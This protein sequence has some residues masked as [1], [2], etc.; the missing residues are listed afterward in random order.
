MGLKGFK[1]VVTG[2]GGFV[3]YHLTQWLKYI[4]EVDVCELDRQSFQNKDIRDK[5]VR[6]ADVVFHLAGVNRDESM[7][8][9][10][11]KNLSLTKNIIESLE[12]TDSSAH[13]VFSSSTQ[14]NLDNLYGKAKKDSRLLFESWAKRSTNGCFT[15]VVIPNVFGPFGRPFYNSVVATF[16]HLFATGGSPEID[17][18]TKLGL[19]YVTDLVK[20]LVAIAQ[21]ERNSI[22]QRFIEPKF[23]TSVKQ[24][25]DKLEE[26]SRNYLMN[27]ELP[28]LVDDFDKALFNTFRSYIPSNF[29]PKKFS[30]HKD[31]R[32]QFVELARTKTPG[33]TSYSTTVPGITRGNHFHT[34]K[35]ER[36][37]VIKGKATVELRKIGTEEVK[38]Y[39][40]DG[41]IPS[42]VDMPV[43]VTHN[44]TNTGNEE[45][46]TVF[47]INEPFDPNDPDTYFEPV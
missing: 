38:T 9:L 37:A 21:S 40:L 32:G 47:W 8:L 11:E 43:W 17:A 34:R 26:I 5:A 46:L 30:T 44:I 31:K 36:F 2:S 14:E 4:E 23:K 27:N 28:S 35:A 20:E 41:N 1:I 24:V 39:H 12:D 42:Y 13:V 3:G 25:F 18:D 29:Y 15:G 6:D 16:C 22:N 10:Y 45:L 33:Q 7:E 19:I